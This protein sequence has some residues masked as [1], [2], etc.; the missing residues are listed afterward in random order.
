MLP[1]WLPWLLQVNDSQ[2]PS[3]AYAHSLGLEELVQRGVVSKAEELGEFLHRQIVP[4]LL[5]FEL[6][7]LAQAHAA[8]AAGNM[9]TLLAMDRELDAWKL[10]AELRAASRRLGS[11]RL[12]LVRR[13]APA[14]LLDT[15]AESGAPC[16]HLIVCALE[17]RATPA[18]AAQCAFAYQTLSGYAYAAMKLMR[19]GQETAQTLVRGAMAA[20]VPHLTFGPATVNGARTGWFNPLLEIASMRHARA[21]E[22]LFIS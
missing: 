9:D 8:G 13:L 4:G 17:L 5:A 7:F 6:P 15:Y 20:M 16:H 22:R 1:E 2:F 14:A 12:A 3:G 19:L 21:T 10:A 18:A 11:R